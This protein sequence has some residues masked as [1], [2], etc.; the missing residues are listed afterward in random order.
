MIG[1]SPLYPITE[2]PLANNARKNLIDEIVKELGDKAPSSATI[3]AAT[4]TVLNR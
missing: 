2:F 1:K 3:D 4:K